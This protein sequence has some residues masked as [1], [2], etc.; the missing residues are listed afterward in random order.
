MEKGGSN[1]QDQ[2][3]SFTR[4]T[5]RGVHR[6]LPPSHKQTAGREFTTKKKDLPRKRKGKGKREKEREGERD[7]SCL[8]PDD[9]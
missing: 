7:S 4:E 5:E 6:W 2:R 8:G 1:T 3:K 9:V